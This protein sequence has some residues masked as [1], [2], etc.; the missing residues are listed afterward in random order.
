MSGGFTNHII[1]LGKQGA[2]KSTIANALADIGFTK[3]V[4]T[5]TRPPRPNEEN[6]FDYWFVDDAIFDSC[7][8]DM[9]AVREYQTVQGLWRYGVDLKD[10]NA[11]GDTVTILD[12]DG[13]L[14]IKDRIKDRFAIYMD[15]PVDIRMGRLLMRGDNPKEIERRERDDADKFAWLDDH[16]R[17]VCDL[18]IRQIASVEDDVRRILRYLRAYNYGEI[19]YD[20]TIDEGDYSVEEE[21]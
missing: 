2:G 15:L 9:V 8:E 20:D 1:L 21:C 17:D 19:R 13:Y 7:K 14:E 18:A 11:D 12:P 6:G 16:Y 3:V 5:T 4:S 10:I